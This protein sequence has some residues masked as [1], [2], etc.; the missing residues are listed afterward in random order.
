MPVLLR[1]R[2]VGIEAVVVVLAGAEVGE[3]VAAVVLPMRLHG[4]TTA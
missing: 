1:L 3:A 4:S 2:P